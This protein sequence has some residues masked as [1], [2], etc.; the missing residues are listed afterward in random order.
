MGPICYTAHQAFIGSAFFI[1][2]NSILNLGQISASLLSRGSRH[3]TAHGSCGADEWELDGEKGRKR[4]W[5]VT[6]LGMTVCG[7][8]VGSSKRQETRHCWT[9]VSLPVLGEWVEAELWPTVCL[10]SSCNRASKNLQLPW[11]RPMVARSLTLLQSV[12]SK[13]VTGEWRICWVCGRN[14]ATTHSLLHTENLLTV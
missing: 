10:M 14:C 9:T 2:M 1:L 13:T 8:T 6:Q 5:T 7:S 3:Q 11:S 12:R 4:C